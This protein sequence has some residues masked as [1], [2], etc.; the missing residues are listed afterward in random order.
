MDVLLSG[1]M[2]IN[3]GQ[4]VFEKKILPLGPEGR[5]G[6]MLLIKLDTPA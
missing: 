3:K 4:K 5:R 1:H 2:A 6:Q